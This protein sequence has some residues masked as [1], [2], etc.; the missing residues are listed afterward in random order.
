MVLKKNHQLK[1]DL[2]K[3]RKLNTVFLI[4]GV[5]EQ[6]KF[7]IYIISFLILVS[8][9]KT[10]V[11]K[12]SISVSDTVCIK[13]DIILIDTTVNNNCFKVFFDSISNGLFFS[14]N[15]KIYKLKT[16][17][18]KLTPEIINN[19]LI[20]SIN[21]FFSDINKFVCSNKIL[22]K[23][24]YIIFTFYEDFGYYFYIFFR[25]ST[26]KN[27]IK[28]LPD[29]VS[30]LVDFNNKNSTYVSNYYIDYSND[31]LVIEDQLSYNSGPY[32]V[33][34]YKIENDTIFKIKEKIVDIDINY[35]NYL[36]DKGDEY[37]YLKLLK[38]M[39]DSNESKKSGVNSLKVKSK[40]NCFYFEPNEYVIS[41]IFSSRLEYG[42]PGYGETP[43]LD[44]KERIFLITI[45]SLIS[46]YPVDS[47]DEKIK[48]IKTFQLANYNYK[49]FDTL[50][51]KRI[52]IE[53][54]FYSAI[55]GHHPTAA[56][57]FVN[58]QNK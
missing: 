49:N 11:S 20:D 51:G 22:I 4:K 42:P 35:Y 36:N 33:S 14:E 8:C 44:Q 24:N 2:M 16:L 46:I 55:N 13:S 48:N 9:N 45:D 25:N 5:T 43:N 57:F 53:G 54:C 31:I 23:N 10:N 17:E 29:N 47:L 12:V 38:K 30:D 28:I 26:K 34:M 21:I 37:V 6:M 19:E 50:I 7:V 27:K 32:L 41:G 52:S 58:E 15:S 3:Y 40:D 56:L 1:I 39:V 18:Y